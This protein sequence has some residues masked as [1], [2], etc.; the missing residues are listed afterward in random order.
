MALVMETKVVQNISYILGPE[1]PRL[2]QKPGKERQANS[3]KK[4]TTHLFLAQLKY[5]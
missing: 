5:F 2:K 3:I 4:T 1:F